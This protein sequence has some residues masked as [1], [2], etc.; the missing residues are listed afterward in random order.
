[1][2]KRAK[3]SFLD[4]FLAIFSSWVH[5]IDL[6]LHI[7]IV[8][9]GLKDL[10]MSPVMFCLVLH[11]QHNL[12]KNWVTPIALI[13]HMLRGLSSLHDLFA[14]GISMI[15]ASIIHSCLSR[16]NSGS[17]PHICIN[18]NTPTLSLSHTHTHTHADTH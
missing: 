10:V 17:H 6:I 4:P 18:T 3:K 1:M 16:K 2:Q 7:K 5:P 9:N 11:D 15:T 14:L 12:C 13:L 8:P